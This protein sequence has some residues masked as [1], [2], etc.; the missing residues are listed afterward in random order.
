M[1]LINSHK[2]A[3]ATFAHSQPFFRH[4]CHQELLGAI[5]TFATGVCMDT[6]KL[7]K[8]HSVLRSMVIK[9]IFPLV[10]LRLQPKSSTQSEEEFT[11]K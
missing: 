2:S 11:C 6:I 10:V 5:V 4:D 8:C 9:K 3:E 7:I 1:L